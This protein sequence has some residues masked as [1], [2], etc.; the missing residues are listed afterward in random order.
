MRRSGFVCV[1]LHV[2]RAHFR[3]GGVAWVGFGPPLVF[4]CVT[5]GAGLCSA[6]RPGQKTSVTGRGCVLHLMKSQSIRSTDLLTL[7]CPH[8]R[9]DVSRVVRS[10]RVV[11]TARC[12]TTKLSKGLRSLGWTYLLYCGADCGAVKHHLGNTTPIGTRVFQT[13]PARAQTSVALDTSVGPHCSR[14]LV[15]RNITIVHGFPSSL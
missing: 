15:P 11:T 2:R 5:W 1:Q 9:A 10:K 4:Q 8:K 6:W 7:R 14:T 13:H 3:S 12:C